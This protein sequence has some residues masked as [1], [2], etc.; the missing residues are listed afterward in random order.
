MS[1]VPVSP[2][3]V[4]QRLLEDVERLRAVA[5]PIIAK[6]RRIPQIRPDSMESV[7]LRYVAMALEDATAALENAR[8]F[9]GS[10]QIEFH[11]TPSLSNAYRI[12]HRDPPAKVTDL[13]AY[14]ARRMARAS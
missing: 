2:A 6:V 5:A 10:V 11:Q 7:Y 14:R 4:H 12:I 1:K 13:D 8:R 3:P 9:G